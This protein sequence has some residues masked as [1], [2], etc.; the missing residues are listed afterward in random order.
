[1]G[2]F[3]DLAEITVVKIL[4][5]D[6]CDELS[7]LGLIFRQDRTAQAAIAVFHLHPLFKLVGIGAYRKSTFVIA[8]K[9]GNIQRHIQ[10]GKLT[11]G[12]QQRMDIQT[13]NFRAVDNQV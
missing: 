7:Q 4:F 2:E 8:I 6:L 10:R 13:L 5:G 12:S 1:M 3:V 9:R 11:G